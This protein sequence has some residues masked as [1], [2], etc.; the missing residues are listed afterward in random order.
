MM[1]RPIRAVPL[2][3]LAMLGLSPAALAVAP[4]QDA[5]KPAA[6]LP[7]KGKAPAKPVARPLLCADPRVKDVSC[8]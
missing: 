3:V 6:V 1:A 4:Q 7:S 2:A 8:Y 5:A